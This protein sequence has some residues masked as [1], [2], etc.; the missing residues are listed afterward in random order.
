MLGRYLDARISLIAAI[1]FCLMGVCLLGGCPAPERP[2]FKKAEPP[3]DVTRDKG[4]VGRAKPDAL[5]EGPR[6]RG[7]E[8]DWVVRNDEIVAVLR[9]R[10]GWLVDLGFRS[11]RHDLFHQGSTVISDTRSK[12]RVYYHTGRVVGEGSDS[13]RLELLGKVR[14][15]DL[16]LEITTH[17][18]APPGKSYLLLESRVRNVGRRPVFRVGI[19]DEMYLG[20]SRLFMPGHGQITKS[21]KLHA[22]WIARE[23]GGYSIALV[24]LEKDPMR[25]RFRFGHQGYNPNVD[26]TYAWKHLEQGDELIARRALVLEPSSLAA[27]SKTIQRLL[28]GDLGVLDIAHPSGLEDGV[29]EEARVLVSRSGH[30]VLRSRLGKKLTRV[31][32]PAG[33]AYEVRLMVAGAGSGPEAT[34]EI[35]NLPMRV[36]VRPPDFGRIDYTVRDEKGSPLP[37]RLTFKGIGSTETPDFGDDGGPQGAVNMVYTSTGKGSRLLAPGRYRIIV[38]SGPER[39]WHT[40]E[41]TVHPGKRTGVEAALVRQVD[42]TGALAADLHLHAVASPDSELSPAERL[43]QLAAE[44]VEIGMAT[45][46]NTISDWS[47]AASA[48]PFKGRVKTFAGCEVTTRRAYFGHFNLYPLSPGS[49]V[50]RY[51]NVSPAMMFEAWKKRSERP[52][53]QINHPRLSFIGTFNQVG[54]VPALGRSFGP[55]FHEGFDA[56]EVFNGDRLYS[57]G[58]LSRN[59]ADWYALLEL[60]MEVTATGGSDSHKLAYH[61]AGYPRSYLLVGHDDPTELSESDLKK[62]VREHRVVVSTGPYIAVEDERGASLVGTRQSQ[63]LE[64]K[65]RVESACWLPVESVE[66]V[67][68]GET[69]RVFRAPAGGESAA[70]DGEGCR[71]FGWSFELDLRPE[72]DTW[73]VLLAKG[74]KHNP[75]LVREGGLVW[76]FTNPIWV[77][78]DGDGRHSSGGSKPRPVR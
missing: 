25:C 69:I 15:R 71:P 27:A 48:P 8:G 30:P 13:P 73:Y 55:G 28:G 9:E 37:A 74:E 34:S 24:S 77:D 21:S 68:N 67:A 41:V 26:S 20:N 39:S 32:L 14:D 22:R 76:A 11:D 10:D 23:A 3:S 49:K 19:G 75:T 47:K 62:A 38:T 42:T 33:S 43:T 60:G 18:S 53:I 17:V 56:V 5:L 52:I 4:L 59:L 51:E 1:S 61:E 16:N 54:F 36:D 31:V 65:V 78:I 35:K 70:E 57:P 6:R 64:A 50:P 66:L 58:R 2:P 29:R 12:Y 46:H 40:A 72:R 7:E 63:R 44:G 45:D